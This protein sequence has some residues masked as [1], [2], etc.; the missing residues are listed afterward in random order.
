MKKILKKIIV[1]ILTILARITLWKY[2]PKIVA[3]V[4]SVGK[5]STK[6]AIYTA[7]KNSYTARK[8]E[9]SLNSDIGVPL[10]ILGVPNAWSSPRGWFRNLIDSFFMIVLPFQYP[11]WL[12]LEVGADRPH[13]IE[14]IARWLKPNIVAVTRISEVPVH[15]EYFENPEALAQ[16]KSNMVK[17]LRPDGVLALNAD[18]ARIAD[19]K[20]ISKAK[21]IFYGFDMQANVKSSNYEILYEKNIGG[22]APIGISFKINYQGNSF[23]IMIKGSLGS[24]HVYPIA[25]ALAVTAGLSLN[26]VEVTAALTRHEAPPGRMKLVSGMEGS[27]IIDDTYNS[28]PVALYEALETLKQ[29]T[30]AGKKIAVLGDMLELGKYSHDE[31]KKAGAHSALCADILMTVGPRAQAI[32]EGAHEAGMKKKSIL[33]FKDAGTAGE[34]LQKVIATG[35]II[36]VKGSQS[37]R[38]ERTVEAIMAHPENKAKLLVRQDEEWKKR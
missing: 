7:I 24:Q 18:D 16:E 28:S 23:P 17:A 19:W 2:K 20:N 12:V 11:E 3:I 10:T 37:M 9:K 5:T 25:A 36:L 15:V 29:I 38:M 31:H 6:D 4:G 34:Y 14:K 8:S 13:D 22:S 26:I 27:V 1:F 35:D 32:V 33:Q 30:C 21:T